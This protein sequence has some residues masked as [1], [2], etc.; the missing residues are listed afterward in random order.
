MRRHRI[1]MAGMEG[2]ALAFA[3][4]GDVIDLFLCELGIGQYLVVGGAR[5]LHRIALADTQRRAR[6]PS[7]LP[8]LDPE[9]RGLDS[10]GPDIDACRDRHASLPSVC[11]RC[12]RRANS[13]APSAPV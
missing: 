5:E 7:G 11:P 2:H 4:G 12:A 3:G 9:Q 1:E 8:I 6:E 13:A 10:A